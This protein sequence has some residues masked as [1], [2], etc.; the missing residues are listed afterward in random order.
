MRQLR[1]DERDEIEAVKH[2]LKYVISKR[3][4]EGY[5]VWE[6]MMKIEAIGH[7]YVIPEIVTEEEMAELI[8]VDDVKEILQKLM[9]LIKNFLKEKEDGELPRT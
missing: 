6:A 2:F 7:K 4:A 3:D 1:E 5:E 9:S 8:E